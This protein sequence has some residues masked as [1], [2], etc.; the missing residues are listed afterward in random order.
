[1]NQR[2]PFLLVSYQVA[3]MHRGASFATFLPF[4]P[5]DSAIIAASMR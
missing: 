1:M 3:L 5:P 4:M 2:Q